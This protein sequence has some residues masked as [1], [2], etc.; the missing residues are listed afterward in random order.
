MKTEKHRKRLQAKLLT[1]SCKVVN[2][3][4]WQIPSRRFYQAMTRLGKAAQAILD[5]E[6]DP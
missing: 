3:C 1:E 6:L 2:F 5:M 4:A